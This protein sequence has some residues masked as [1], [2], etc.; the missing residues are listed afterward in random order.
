MRERTENQTVCSMHLLCRLPERGSG[1]GE[2]A[3][4]VLIL[5]SALSY[6]VV[7][8]VVEAFLQKKLGQKFRFVVT[9]LN[10]Q[11]VSLAYKDLFVQF[12]FQYKQSAAAFSTE[13]LPNNGE[14][15]DFYHAQQ[16]S[17]EVRVSS[18]V[19]LVFVLC[20]SGVSFLSP[21]GLA[22]LCLMYVSVL[23]MSFSVCLCVYICVCLC[24]SVGY[25]A[26]VS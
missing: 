2:K 10:V 9:V 7:L 20:L 24:L 26:T 8:P 21:F 25:E 18:L 17:V 14:S 5:F 12:G 6:V 1:K 3:S 19:S 23:C 16:V 13:G 22:F 15:L 11:G 4:L